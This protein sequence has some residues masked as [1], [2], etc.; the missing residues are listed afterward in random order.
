VATTIAVSLINR[1][2]VTLQDP[3]FVRWTQ[4]ELLD[5]LN[6]AQRQ[7]VLFR[8]D[9]KTVNSSFVCAATS[10]QTLPA[11]G[12]RLLNVLRNTNGR[13]VTKVSR[14]TLDVQLP[15]WYETAINSEGV[16]H[17]VYDA[18]DPKIFYLFPKPTVSNQIDIVYSVSPVD[19]T[20]SNFATD[21][22]VI[23]IDDV[24]AN[25]IMDYMMYRAYQ[26]DSEF[27]NLNRSGIYYQSFNNALGIKS[28]A[29]GGLLQ[30]MNAVQPGTQME[31][32]S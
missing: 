3:T 17:Y 32:G 10:K 16:K 18:L 24:Y 8:P 28:Q 5:Y 30:N 1:V 14:K 29:D 4:Q 31:D 13:A 15:N 2:A 23:S 12:L 26:K 7:V 6:D 11:D 22:Q 21:T 20:I 25:A 27:A 9:A 19:I